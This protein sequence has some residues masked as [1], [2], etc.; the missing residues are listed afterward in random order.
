MIFVFVSMVWCCLDLEHGKDD[1]PGAA[2]SV[3]VKPCS[4]R[5]KRWV[6]EQHLQGSER[7]I[8]TAQPAL[9]Q[10]QLHRQRR[11]LLLDCLLADVLLEQILPPCRGISK[12][13]CDNVFNVDT[14]N[15]A[16]GDTRSR[17]LGGVMGS[18]LLRNKR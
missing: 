13:F 8:A 11:Q 2:A 9:H 18:T 15:S 1:A 16:I 5:D 10:R 4:K 17:M 7:L 12:T 14:P 3:R 6:Q